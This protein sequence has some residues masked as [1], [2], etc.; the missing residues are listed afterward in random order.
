MALGGD[1]QDTHGFRDLAGEPFGGDRETAVD[2]HVAVIGLIPWDIDAHDIL[3][4]ALVRSANTRAL[5]P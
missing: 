2:D 3:H 5:P 4:V 1:G